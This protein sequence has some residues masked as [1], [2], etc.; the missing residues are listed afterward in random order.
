MKEKFQLKNN[1]V[2]ALILAGG[3]GKRLDI[4]TRFTAKPAIPFGGKYRII[5]FTLSNC[6]NSGI[7]SVG[8]L[9]QYQPLELS[10]YIGT[11]KTWDLDRIHGGITILP[12]YMKKS[13]SDWYKGTANA[14]FQNINYIEE[15]NP[16]YV[17][18]LSGDHIYKMNY[19]KMLEFHKQRGADCTI[20]TTNVSLSDAK[21][22]GLVITDKNEKITDFE[23]KPL[24]PKST[25][26]SMGVYI[27]NW[28]TLKKY[29]ILD[30]NRENSSNDFGKDVLPLM[31]RDGCQMF[32]YPFFGYWRDVGT[33]E[34]LWKANMDLISNSLLTR[35]SDWKIYSNT[36]P[37]PPSI[38][39]KN[40]EIKSSI[41]AEGCIIHGKVENSVVFGNVKIA[42]GA[43]V[44]NS[45]IFS[46][47][48]V[49]KG[50]EVINCLMDEGGRVGKNCKV[51]EE[52]FLTVLKRNSKVHNALL[53]SSDSVVS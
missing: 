16:K 31:L 10:D 13:G 18:V 50:A 4:L 8:V 38:I 41:I 6:T 7:T 29:L 42:S 9:T 33:T 2:I 21:R 17:I 44:K 30:N 49:S 15:T 24:V 12:P 35:N 47:S 45:V 5:D 3:Q 43:I 1:K 11:G 32:A 34:S 53:E 23:E 51:G 52:G 22:F 14:V 39:S 19:S 46:N 37:T 26:A 27:F 36:Y 20:A 48:T 40:S 25:K 28:Q